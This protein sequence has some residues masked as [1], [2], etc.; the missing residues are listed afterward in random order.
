MA[1]SEPQTNYANTFI[2]EYKRTL[3]DSLNRDILHIDLKIREEIVNNAEDFLNRLIRKGYLS[4]NN[5]S[6]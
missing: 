2:D 1:L 5:D 4:D 3:T 6:R